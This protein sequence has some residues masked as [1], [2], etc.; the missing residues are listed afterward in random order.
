MTI[1][2]KNPFN[3][4]KEEGKFLSY[5]SGY[6][7][8]SMEECPYE[9]D[10]DDENRAFRVAWTRGFKANPGHKAALDKAKVAQTSPEAPNVE[11]STPGTSLTT[12]S[13]ELLELELKKRKLG[14]LEELSKQEQTLTAQLQQVQKQIHKLSI[15]LGD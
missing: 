4:Q 14:E 6:Y 8:A 2:S 13:T 5:E 10:D 9:E 3:E 1:E 12:I 7:A 15:L 11:I